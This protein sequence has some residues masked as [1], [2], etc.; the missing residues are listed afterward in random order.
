MDTPHSPNGTADRVLP[1]MVIGISGGTWTVINAMLA[2]GGL[3]NLRALIR[4]GSSGVL[5]SVK[6][7]GDRHYRPQTAWP[8][9][10]TGKRPER[11]G[12]TEYY[13]TFTDLK[14][15]C[16]WD[17]FSAKGLS[18]GLYAAPVL[19]PPPKINGF[20]V[21]LMYARDERAWPEELNDLAAYFRRQQDSKLRPST[22]GL[23][24]RSTR[25]LPI[26]FGRRRDWRIP[27]SML[28]SAA[29]LAIER[30]PETR[31][32]IVRHAKLDFST[33]MFLDLRRKFAPQLSIFISFE[34][35]FIS[36]RYWRYHEPEKFPPRPREPAPR[37]NS[38]VKDAYAHM[39]RCIGA[40]VKDL[41]D[42]HVVA[43]VSEHG[44]TAEVP[45]GEIGRWRYMISAEKVKKS[46]GIGTDIVAI[47]IARWVVFRRK[48]GGAL[49]ESISRALGSL[50]VAETGLPLFSVH[51]H[52]EDEVVIKLNLGR[53]GNGT[54]DDIGDLHVTIPQAGVV[55][56]VQ[57]LQR[58]GPT[59]SAMHHKDGVFVVKG[60][61]IRS[62]HQVCGAVVTDVMPT[63]LCAAGLT[64][65]TDIDGKTLDLFV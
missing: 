57:L 61:G 28:R 24:R 51:L 33:A 35:D 22:W 42:D 15:A 37:L 26:F 5:E 1:V 36:H 50:T 13:H 55:P 4:A 27:L 19:W 32:L 58:A 52:G 60:P 25:F 38:A 45:S 48:D 2:E 34:L 40:L 11:H 43:V 62:G 31:S 29:R 30:D 64:P 12:I 14:S 18:A 41:P 49:D 21:P 8:S 9:V 7:P 59:R 46:I 20:I 3:P 39:D 54:T 23:A 56:I 65:P 53:E 63:L 6:V 44:M 16:L 10:F 17:S 47:P